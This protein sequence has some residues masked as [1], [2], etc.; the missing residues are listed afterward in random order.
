VNRLGWRV[1]AG[2]ERSVAM[3][4]AAH[5]FG[6]ELAVILGALLIV[7]AAAVMVYRRIARPIAQLASATRED[8]PAGGIA[9]ETVRGSAE[10]ADLAERFQGLI[11]RLENELSE[12]RR[13]ERAA[14]AA[15]KAARASAEGLPPDVREQPAAD[16]DL[17]HRHARDHRGQRGCGRG[18]TATRARSSPR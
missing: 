9:P 11:G 18:T 13:A 10:V 1:Y 17:R 4:S 16:V 6:H 12:R 8:R 5:L 2:L 15:E 7:L 14:R 3:A